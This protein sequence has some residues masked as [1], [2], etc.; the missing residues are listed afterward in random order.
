MS[1]IHVSLSLAV[2]NEILSAPDA[3][4]V[5]VLCKILT[6]MDLTG[7]AQSTIKEMKI[8]TARMI[9]VP[10]MLCIRFLFESSPASL[11]RPIPYAKCTGF[12]RFTVTFFCFGPFKNAVCGS[13]VTTTSATQ[14]K[15][16]PL[17]FVNKITIFR[18]SFKLA[19]TCKILLLNC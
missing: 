1:S 13:F 11:H 15:T 8:L 4:G 17:H 14:K 9:E 12:T 18:R 6:M 10:V 3:P 19:I 5:R 2:A 16:M 7:C